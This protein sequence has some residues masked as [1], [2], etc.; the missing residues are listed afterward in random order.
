MQNA[1]TN[2]KEKDALVILKRQQGVDPATVTI[3]LSSGNTMPGDAQD[4]K[5]ITINP[6]NLPPV[7]LP[8]A[9]NGGAMMN[10]DYVM[11]TAGHPARADKSAVIRINL[12]TSPH[13]L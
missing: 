11:R 13:H 12:R 5:I 1:V 4:I 8:K 7:F 2:K 9:M 6:V 10:F 3:R